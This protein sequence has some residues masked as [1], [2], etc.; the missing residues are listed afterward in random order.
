MTPKNNS[1]L[2]ENEVR[3]IR[4]LL[5]GKE[6]E[7]IRHLLMDKKNKVLL[8]LLINRENK[9]LCELSRRFDVTPTQLISKD[10]SWYLCEIRYIYYK[11]RYENHGLSYAE[12]AREIGR[13]HG[14]VRYGVNK[15]NGLLRLNDTK[16]TE[17]WKRA[18][19]IPGYYM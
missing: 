17:M 8:E 4:S 11:L 9:V 1:A 2:T 10:T 7:P 12:I 19:D 6:N 3:F 15:I 5:M 14:A 16:A 18:K 13:S